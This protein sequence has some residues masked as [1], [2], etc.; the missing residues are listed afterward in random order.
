MKHHLNYEGAQI[1][2]SLPPDW[3]LISTHHKPPAPVVSDARAE[4]ERALDNP[5][6]SPRIEDI[7]RPGMDVV[8]LFDDQQR[9]TPA[10]LAL[11]EIMNRLNSAGVPDERMSAICAGATHPHPTGEEL[12]AKV[13]GHVLSRLKGRISSHDPHS[14]ENVIVGRTSRGILVEINKAVA[15]ADLT[16]GVGECMPHPGAGYGGGY[17]IIMP[18]VSSYRSVAEH[19]FTFMR[20][21][22]SR[23][24]VLDGNPFWEEI[25]D[26]GRLAGLAFKLDL[27]MN[28]RKQVIK[29][30]AGDPEAEQR[31]AAKFAE[32]QYLVSLPRRA[33]VTIT[34]AYPLEIGVQA[35]KALSMASLCTRSGGTIIWVASQK[36]AG[37]ILPLI[38]EMASPLSAN[39]VHRALVGGSIPEHLRSF[40]ISY[41]VQ[42]VSYKELTEKFNVI[43]VTEGLTPEQVRMMHM[44]YSGNLQEAI[45][46][47][48]IDMPKA[49]VAVFP[50][51]GSIIPEVSGGTPEG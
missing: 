10:H 8:L 51:G 25:V 16:V 9:P 43:H 37:A 4:I 23:V 36:Q 31:E 2:F 27:V 11:P 13:G 35:T 1:F 38:E 19:H 6:G 39:E 20:N 17:K 42:I 33:D 12:L 26:A 24:N 47:L 30:F 29:A 21:R 34:S 15:R 46:G 7:A 18:G 49:E 48:A 28:A 45:D 14:P 32:A 44:T 3:S 22:N 5:I 50:S 40:G 41:I